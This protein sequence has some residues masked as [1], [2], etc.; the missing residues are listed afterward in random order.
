M[1]LLLLLKAVNDVWYLVR[2]RFDTFSL[3]VKNINCLLIVPE[4]RLSL[5]QLVL[6]RIVKTLKMEIV[7]LLFK[8]FCPLLEVHY[9]LLIEQ[10]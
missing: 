2:Y 1:D 8:D 5:S 4:L 6:P 7:H 10:L 9:L 3:V